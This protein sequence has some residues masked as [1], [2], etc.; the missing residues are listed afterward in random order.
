MRALGQAA[1]E[2]AHIAETTGDRH[3]HLVEALPDGE[4]V[5]RVESTVRDGTTIYDGSTVFDRP[6]EFEDG[7]FDGSRV[8]DQDSLFD[9][10][11]AFDGSSALEEYDDSF[12]DDERDDGAQVLSLAAARARRAGHPAGVDR[13]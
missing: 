9:D 5:R 10:G 2:A 11:L 12:D 13:D 7:Y 4:A 1:R 3:L 6:E 8:F